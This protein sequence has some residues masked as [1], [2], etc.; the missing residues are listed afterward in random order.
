MQSQ[1]H[2]RENGVTGAKQEKVGRQQGGTGWR[3]RGVGTLLGK[4]E[5][6]KLE[7]S[8]HQLVVSHRRRLVGD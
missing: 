2:F 6:C 5:D 1:S 7:S 8:D 4:T 3:L